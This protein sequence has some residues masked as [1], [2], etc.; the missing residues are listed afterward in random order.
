MGKRKGKTKSGADLSRREFLRLAG[1]AAA[2]AAL[3]GAGLLSGCA[4]NP[5]TGR[6]QLMLMSEADE[7]KADHQY[8]PLQHS[9]DF[10]YDHDPV[11]SQYVQSVGLSLARHSDRPNMPYNY[12]VV[13]AVYVNAYAFPGGSIVCTRGIMAG[14]TNEAQ[15][16]ALLGH[17][18]G[19][20]CAR[21]TA[22]RASQGSI[23]SVILSGLGA[24]LGG[25]VGGQAAQG[26][27]GLG[28]GALMAS[29]SRDDERQAD[30]LGME[31]MVRAGYNP[32]GMIQ[33]MDFLMSQEKERPSDVSKIFADHP[34]SDERY[35]TALEQ[36]NTRYPQAR[37]LPLLQA[38]FMD[39]TAS[40][41][42]MAGVI[43]AL[44]DGDKYMGKKNYREA[45]QA[46]DA[47]LTKA[48][49]DY[50]GLLMMTRCQAAMKN[51]RSAR[52]YVN[53]AKRVYPGEGQ[54]VL[55]S[56]GVAM[57][58]RDY[59]L[60]YS[61]FSAYD[62]IFPDNPES[63]FLRGLAREKQGRTD[64]AANLYYRFLQNGGQGDEAQYAYSRLVQWGYVRR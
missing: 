43:R 42:R 7:I 15:L 50:A 14:M 23:L 19:H 46:F 32:L 3:S 13:N 56:G 5:V 2:G 16:A 11:L 47:A 37:D 30:A 44:Q 26:L 59:D 63:T 41:R 45:A 58:E 53:A 12:H 48:P 61:E 51:W 55:L 21:H 33:L 29:Y 20:V 54:A 38:R 57:Q 52:Q 8:A 10:G 9:H 39:H 49:E 34:M 40:I 36:A 6:S 25:G 60:A 27:G 64:E 1:V 62:K 18:T 35:R 31:Y 4:V 24:A 22:A 28:A 17:E